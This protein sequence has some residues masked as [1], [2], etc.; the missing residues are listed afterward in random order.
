MK[1][2]FTSI[3]STPSNLRIAGYEVALSDYKRGRDFSGWKPLATG[4]PYWS[5]GFSAG[6]E[7][8]LAME[9][10]WADEE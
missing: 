9:A 4:N 3:E 1:M 5:E 7:Y 6:V 10:M 2:L 8:C